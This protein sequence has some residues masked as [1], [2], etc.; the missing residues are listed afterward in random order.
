MNVRKYLAVAVATAA[1]SA[2]AAAAPAH[3]ATGDISTVAGTGTGGYNIADDGGDATL[4]QIYNPFG[5]AVDS[6]GNLFITDYTNNRIRKVTAGGIITTV[7]GGGSG[8]YGEGGLATA[9]E[10]NGPNDV[11]VDAAGNL[12]IADAGNNRIR[13]VDHITRNIT[14]IAGTGASSFGGDGFAAT[15]ATLNYPDSV[16]LDSAGNLYIADYYNHRIRKVTAATGIITTVAGSGSQGNTGD[17][18]AATAATL[19][20][21]LD[22]IVDSAGNIYIADFGN[23]RVRK[24]TAGSGI[25]TAFAGSNATGFTGDG[26][27]ATGATFGGQVGYLA[28]DGDGNLYIPDYDNNRI[29]KITA[30]TGIITT[31][32]GIGS[33]ASS[34]DN[35]AA[36]A[37]ELNGPWAIEFN[38]A[39]DL[40]IA[41][42]DGNT[43]RKVSGLGAPFTL[44]PTGAN[45]DGLVWLAAALL[46][47][48][49]VLVTTRRR[50]TV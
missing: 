24:V 8:G 2:F 20:R 12:Y 43:I 25:I 37:A 6:D 14:T 22:A 44:P 3:A 18:L 5:M 29:R 10:L 30:S 50:H 21:P 23:N 15:L 31:V 34:G 48:G 33:R 38:T 36:T 4:A 41:E 47:A 1:V 32:A 11:A 17:G 39:G 27:V 45:T 7:A 35:G 16:S 40:F 19:N 49:A 42:Y 26:D 13:K 9:A 46:G 28:L